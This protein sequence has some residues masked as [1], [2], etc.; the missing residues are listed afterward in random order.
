VDLNNPDD[1][2]SIDAKDALAD[3]EATATQWSEA[4]DLFPGRLA[5]E[6]FDNVVIS[7]M[8]GSGIAGDVLWA[9]SLQGYERPIVVHKGYG[10]PP[11]TGPRTLVVI[12]SH[13]GSTEEALSAFEQAGASGAA[14]L[15]VTSG[16][17]L[18]AAASSEAVDVAVLP[19]GDRQPRHSLGFLLVPAM[20][21]LGLDKGLDEAVEVLAALAAD[22][23]RG[24]PIE[25]NFA[26]QVAQRLARNVVPVVWGGH[27]IGSVAAYRLKC[28]LNE[29]AKLPAVHG[30]LPEVDHN[31]VV[32]WE[33]TSA[34]TGVTALLSLRDPA[35]EHP[36]VSRRFAITTDLLAQ[37]L[38]WNIEITARGSSPLARA[39][40]LLIQADL[41]SVYTAIAADRDPTPIASIDRL[42]SQL[43]TPAA[44]R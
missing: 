44:V 27:G 28:Q 10:V 9:L 25:D 8:G 1:F 3:V 20:V 4:A 32:G 5:M 21:A 26:K 24:V 2:G 12:F 23:G 43:G 22:L 40:S 15:V 36:R 35:G 39:A 7:G 19:R 16:G 11:F 17:A 18:G 13:S 42:K 29:N 37:R 14:R 31:D 6:R 30:E 41:V 34:L 38:A 33:H